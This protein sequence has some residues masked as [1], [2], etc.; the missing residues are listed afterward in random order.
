MKLPHTY[1]ARTSGGPAGPATIAVDGVGELSSATTPDVGGT[2]DGWSPG[3]LLLAALEGCFLFTF[4]AIARN[5]KL[6]FLKLEVTGEGTVDRQD[7]VTRFVSITLRPRLTLPTGADAARAFRIL[8]KSERG[9]LVAN[10]LK[11]SVVLE[12]EIVTA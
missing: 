12:P 5:S 10:S 6:A 3:H 11:T 9:C 2:G 7:G 4:Q 1:S 8:E